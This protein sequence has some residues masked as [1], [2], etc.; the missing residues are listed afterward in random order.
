MSNVCISSK[1]CGTSE[2]HKRNISFAERHEKWFKN[3][4]LKVRK[5]Q[6]RIKQGV[7][8]PRKYLRSTWRW[9]SK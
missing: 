1:T 6:W 4:P 5:V 7:F 9:N 8:V 2:K 3:T